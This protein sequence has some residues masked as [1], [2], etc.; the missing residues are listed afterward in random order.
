MPTDLIK[1]PGGGHAFVTRAVDNS[2]P[3]GG[4]HDE[5][6]AKLTYRTRKGDER[7]IN[8]DKYLIPGTTFPRKEH[9][10]MR[11]IGGE[12]ACSKCGCGY[13]QSHNIHLL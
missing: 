4:E 5:N 9:L 7:Y 13:T 3:A 10:R 6:G 1:F 11:I 8:Q 12:V 2:C